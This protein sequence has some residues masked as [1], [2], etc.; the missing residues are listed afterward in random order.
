[1]DDQFD[2]EFETLEMPSVSKSDSCTQTEPTYVQ[3]TST[4]SRGYR[5]SETS[6][7]QRNNASSSSSS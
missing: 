5:G 3:C 2:D 7:D 6:S 4:N 1:M